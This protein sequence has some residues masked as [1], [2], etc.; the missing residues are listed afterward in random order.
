MRRRLVL[1][2]SLL[3]GGLSAA[4]AEPL[5]LRS[6]SQAGFAHKYNPGGEGPQGFCIDYIQA[7]KRVD[8]GLDFTGLQQMLPTPRIEQ[9]LAAGRIDVFFAM[10]RTPEREALYRFVDSPRLYTIHHQIA[11]LASDAQAEQVRSFADLRALRGEG[12]VLTTRGSGYADFLRGQAGL[13]VDDG[14]ASLE[15]NLRKLVGGRA[16]FLYDSE[17]LLQRTIQAMDLQAQVSV[18]PTVFRRQDL[19]LAHTPWLPAERLARVVA[20]MQALE[21]SGG[22][23]RLRVAYGL[24]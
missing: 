23:A 5:V 1:Q 4:P 10:L 17:S 15:Q 20:A 6:A 2:L 3:P 16:R 8:A 21:A 24:R 11:V 18:L 19:A 7:L 22:A 12:R 13:D 14:A 9:D